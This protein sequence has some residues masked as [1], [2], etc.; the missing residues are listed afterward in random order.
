M[1]YFKMVL[2]MRA[3]DYKN[4]LDQKQKRVWNVVRKVSIFVIFQ[5]KFYM[6][7]IYTYKLAIIEEIE[8]DFQRPAGNPGDRRGQIGNCGCTFSGSRRKGR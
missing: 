8:I 2:A 4:A 6:H 3:H 5:P 7:S 1:I